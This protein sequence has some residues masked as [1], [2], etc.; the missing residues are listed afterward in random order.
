[1]SGTTAGYIVVVSCQSRENNTS[2]CFTDEFSYC[3]AIKLR[4]SVAQDCLS[5]QRGQSRRLLRHN[6]CSTDILRS[7]TAVSAGM[8]EKNVGQGHPVALSCTQLIY[9]S[10][11]PGDRGRV[12]MKPF[13]LISAML[14]LRSRCRGV[15]REWSLTSRCFHLVRSFCF[16]HH[17]YNSSMPSGR[18]DMFP[19]FLVSGFSS[20]TPCPVALLSYRSTSPTCQSWKVLADCG[21]TFVLCLNDS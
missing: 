13:A 11:E 18:S 20:M 19:A 3:S 5:D 21:R 4:L 12:T 2:H 9:W 16:P 14:D 17:T 1:M 8:S 7:R 10:F 6:S 15:L